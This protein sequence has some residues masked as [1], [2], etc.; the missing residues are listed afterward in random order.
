MDHAP[1]PLSAIEVAWL[2]VAGAR[3]MVDLWVHVAGGNKS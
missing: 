3:V 2:P 1:L